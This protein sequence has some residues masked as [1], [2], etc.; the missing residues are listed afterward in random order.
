MD[1]RHWIALFVAA[2]VPGA[3]LGD[4][5]PLALAQHVRNLTPEQAARKHPVRLTGVVTYVNP[6]VRD[7]CVQDS[8]AGIY[9]H[10]SEH[11]AGL[12]FGD[13]VT[14]EGVSDAGDFAPCVTPSAVTV[15][16]TG[17][18]PDPLPFSLMIDDSRWL[19]GQWVQAWVV[20]R[21]VSVAGPRNTGR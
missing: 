1:P 3:A 2:C 21:S 12:K 17:K 18:V 4:P 19:D 10:P 5:P 7:F 20:V 15:V 11:T 14:V 8:S 6:H 16:G 13:R 9:V